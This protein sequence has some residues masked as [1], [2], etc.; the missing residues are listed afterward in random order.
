MKKA[1][2]AK[3]PKGIDQTFVDDI[4]SLS[5]ESLQERV[6]QYQIANAENEEFKESADFISAQA[7]FDQAKER[8][9]LVAGPVRDTTTAIKN[10][11][12]LLI[13]RLRDKGAL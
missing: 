11:T 1:D 9:Q 5:V 10:K 8:Y 12:K 4:Q 2:T 6:Y 13:E 7:E 3:L